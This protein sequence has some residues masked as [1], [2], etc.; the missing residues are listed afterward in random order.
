MSRPSRRTALLGS[1]AIL[2][3]VGV[4]VL[5]AAKPKAPPER[6]DQWK[7]VDDAVNKGLPKTA[8]QELEPIIA[9]ALKDKAY[10]EAIRAIA[11]KVA[12][13]GNIQG[14][15]PEERITR[16]KAEIAKAPPEM[17]PVMDTILAHWYWHYYQQNRWRFVQRTATSAPPGEDFTTWDLPRL[18]A[19]IDKQFTKALAAE[20]ELK[21]T[22]IGT[23]D[24]L[25]EK[26]T[27]PDTY[28][29][30]LYD[31]LA[32]EA[33]EFYT[34]AEQAGARP[35]D[36]F[37]ISADSPALGMVDEF[38]KWQPDT[39]DAGAPKLK[40]IK[41][42]QALLTFHKDD[43]DRSA[44]LDADLSRL[45]FAH[46]SAFGDSKAD[47]YKA[48]LQKIAETYAQHELSAT[49]RY[50]W[51]SVLNGEGEHVQA[52]EIALE[53]KR[54]FPESAGGKLCHNLILQIE[55]KEVQITAERVWAD[56]LPPLRVTYK[57]ITKVHF[58]AVKFDWASRLTR[59]RWRPEMLTD[60]DRN[61]LVRRKPELV[62]SADLPPTP[63][64]HERTEDIPAPK[65]L[66]PGFYFIVASP[67]A[68]FGD[69]ENAVSAADVW[70]SDLAL[71]MR[72]EWGKGKVEGF[73]LK[74]KSGDPVAGAT[75]RTWVRQ[76]DG[77]LAQGPQTKT[78]QNG[79]FSVSGNDR[80]GFFVLATSHD[81]QELA[82]GNEYR[83]YTDAELYRPNAHTVFF[84]DR[85]LYRPGQT[86]HYKGI[87]LVAD[88]RADKYQ[89]TPNRKVTVVFSDPNGKEVA[90]REHV[91]NDFGSFSGSF[92]APRDRLAGRMTISV[93]YAGDGSVA[94]NVEE[95]KRPKFQVTVEA[96]KDAP[97][98][99]GEVTI[100]GKATAYT[101][102][103]IGGA[104][105]HFRVTREVRWPVWFY[106]CCWWRIPPNRGAA[107]EIAH[108]TAITEPDGSFT[109]KFTAKPDA[110]VPEKDEPTFHFTVN[111][112]V[113]DSTGETRSG[114]K[115]VVVG[116]T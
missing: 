32:F 98:L 38:L 44:F 58:R 73:V 46:A 72:N 8:I 39:T 34:A 5:V 48:A 49:A 106:D 43:Q 76:N 90:R 77:G 116:Y 47:R 102:A 25:L 96:P 86:I 24:A 100:L 94:F 12:L 18:F 66:A 14:N 89:V 52:R 54:A 91:T 63:D 84:T 20:K 1:A 37:E 65:G 83:N 99:G 26:G 40:A 2:V 22:P 51:A 81:G 36:A 19:E 62:W 29:P 109:V 104:K 115:S 16:L 50:N 28:R 23:Y 60:A 53:G 92:T 71:V 21:A 69:N 79:L 27:L 82:S 78:D 87:C 113:T 103:A 85:S 57:N 80:G 112:D 31:F 9:A 74:A 45:Q 75:I 6:A 101:G 11:K 35:E 4:V 41:L 68:N 110:S 114:S 93:A 17:V 15:K 61:E 105:V 42:Y 88:T 107:Q 59:D 10:P 55:A 70:V 13:E 3:A 67:A 33:L 7:K 64:Y 56:P 30:T 111:A 95:Y 97:K 108:G